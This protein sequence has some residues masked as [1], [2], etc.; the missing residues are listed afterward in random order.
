M[1]ECLPSMS[2]ALGSSPSTR[3]Q[4]NQEFLKQEKNQPISHQPKYLKF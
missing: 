2:E 3:K 4:K 1:A